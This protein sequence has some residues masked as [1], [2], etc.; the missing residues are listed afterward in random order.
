MQF[1]N[2]S[3][4]R[5]KQL[6]SVKD[7]PG[8]KSPPHRRYPKEHFHEIPYCFQTQAQHLK[9]HHDHFILTN[10]PV[11]HTS[12]ETHD[13]WLSRYVITNNTIYL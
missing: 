11:F 9:I 1:V 6:T 5:V 8:L 4:Q 3:V 10:I 12:Y 7:K 2:Q 13:K